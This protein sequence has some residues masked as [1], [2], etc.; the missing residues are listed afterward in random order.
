LGQWNY[1]PLLSSD[2][3]SLKGRECDIGRLRIPTIR[4]GSS[5][6]LSVLA[7]I[8]RDLLLALMEPLHDRRSPWY[9]RGLICE[10]LP[11]VSVILLHDVEGRFLG[12][13][14]MVFGK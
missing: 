8:F 6:G 4:R 11:K 3:D 5:R 9:Q 14:S 1:R 10:A 12:E 13:L 7:A 2:L